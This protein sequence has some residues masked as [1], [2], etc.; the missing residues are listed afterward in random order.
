MPRVAGLSGT[1]KD[2]NPGARR[3]T[4]ISAA[5]LALAVTSADGQQ[6]GGIAGAASP[7]RPVTAMWGL[8]CPSPALG[9][10]PSRG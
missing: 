4:W 3:Q 10:W 9:R 5:A 7:P 8:L 6:F 1:L 2:M